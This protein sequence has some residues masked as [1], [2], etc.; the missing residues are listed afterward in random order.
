MFVSLKAMA[1][2]KVD[3][4]QKA[5]IFKVDPDAVEF[6]EGFNLR[7]EGP[8]LDAHLNALYEAMKSGAFVPPIDV[9]VVDGRVIVRDGH[10]RTRVA[11]RL[12]SEGIPYHLE[13]RQ[14]RGNE[15]ECVFHM[16]SS[17]Q[18]KS[19]TPLEQGRGFMRLIR[20][21]LDVQAIKERTGLSRTTIEN[22]LMLAEAPVEV[23]QMVSRGE[24]ATQVALDML[25]KH[26]TKAAEHL[27]PHIDK[28][29]AEGGAKVTR[30]H[31]A[32]PRVPTRVVQSFISATAAIRE[33]VG[34]DD[35]EAVM[36]LDDDKLIQVPVRALKDLLAAHAEVQKK[37]ESAGE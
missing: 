14:F 27:R 24:V 8:E 26:G 28:V 15:T 13:A 12:K 22:G 20:Y 9:S 36:S 37:Q 17:A 10:C 35:I 25:R 32:T 11:R 19:L 5:T 18:G 34:G 1:E 33:A 7:E 29:K 30:K 4:I 2:S 3:G 23:Q 16:I 31:V 21:G 6:E